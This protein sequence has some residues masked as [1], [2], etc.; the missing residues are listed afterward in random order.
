MIR[1]GSFS[2]KEREMYDPEKVITLEPPKKDSP[3]DPFAEV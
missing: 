3:Y 1:N 2:M